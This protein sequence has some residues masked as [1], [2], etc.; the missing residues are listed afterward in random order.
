MTHSL[1]RTGSESSLQR[2]FVVLI[3]PA[4]GVNAEGATQKLKEIVD[5]IEALGPDNI[6][7]FMSGS[8]HDGHDFETIKWGLE[9][10]SVPRV[11]CCFSDPDRV[12]SLVRHIKEKD[13]GLSVTI[14]GLIDRI[15]KM[16]EHLDI[17]PH[18]IN[19]SLGVHGRTDQLPEPQIMNIVTMCGHGMISP[20]RV[21][22]LIDRVAS[23]RMSADEAAGELARPCLCGIFNR[24]RARI[25]L[26]E[27]AADA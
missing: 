4:A 23:G 20:Q 17:T 6:G 7:D 10:A 5:V 1:H 9:Q 11:R 13:Y 16:C 22:D 12:M 3:T 14:S 21:S 8:I 25:L 18:S 2:D 26:T 19:L 15:Q 27:A 24:E